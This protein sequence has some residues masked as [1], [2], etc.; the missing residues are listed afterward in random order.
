VPARGEKECLI[1]H[2]VPHTA[3]SLGAALKGC[4]VVR[5]GVARVATIEQN[6]R[7]STKNTGQTKNLQPAFDRPIRD[8]QAGMDRPRSILRRGNLK[9]KSNPAPGVR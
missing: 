4:D 7:G 9:S 1:R 8:P 5:V 6:L 2:S 3:L